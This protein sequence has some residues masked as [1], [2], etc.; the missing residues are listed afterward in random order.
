MPVMCSLNKPFTER[1]A[2]NPLQPP[3]QVFG[4]YAGLLSSVLSDFGDL[5]HI[6]RSGKS[7]LLASSVS[8]IISI[9]KKKKKKNQLESQATRII[10]KALAASM[11]LSWQVSVKCFTITLQ[12]HTESI[13][14]LLLCTMLSD[15]E[16]A[17]AMGK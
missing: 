7:Y 12:K 14:A 9:K 11:F 6:H 4:C 15:N 3:F 16:H 1:N 17:N 10:K 13:G 8:V 5:K 2:V